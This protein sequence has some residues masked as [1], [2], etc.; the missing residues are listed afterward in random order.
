MVGWSFSLSF[1]GIIIQVVNCMFAIVVWRTENNSSVFC[2]SSLLSRSSRSPW[3]FADCGFD[4][5]DTVMEKVSLF[6]FVIWSIS[7][8]GAGASPGKC[9][10]LGFCS[11]W[12]WFQA[13]LLPLGIWYFY[14]MGTVTCWT[15][16]DFGPG[17][18]HR[19]TGT[20]MFGWIWALCFVS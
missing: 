6:T 9:Y 4:F 13:L 17:Q 19:P 10:N 12:A 7:G 15:G 20:C 14:L 5:R 3:K 11:L 8:D 16:P 1:M 2:Y 18:L